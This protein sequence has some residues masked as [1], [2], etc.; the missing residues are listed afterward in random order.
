VSSAVLQ[1][2]AKADQLFRVVATEKFADCITQ[3]FEDELKAT[4]DGGVGY[5]S[6]VP[7]ITRDRVEAADH[8]A[9]ITAPFTLEIAPVSL[10]GQVDL[11][12]V[13]TGQAFSLLFG[14]SLGDPIGAVELGHVTDLLVA[15]QQV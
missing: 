1:S 3:A 2:E 6:G 8:S 5:E 12:M 4:A 10:D 14:F 15:R 13:T 9:Q 7:R 11:V